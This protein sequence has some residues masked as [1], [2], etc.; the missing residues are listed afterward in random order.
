MEKDRWLVIGMATGS[1]DLEYWE[2]DNTEIC[3]K[4]CEQLARDTGRNVFILKGEVYAR[5][6]VEV[7]VKSEMIKKMKADNK[8]FE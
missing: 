6:Y 1:H 3:E 4:F 5:F 7:P 8:T 2:F